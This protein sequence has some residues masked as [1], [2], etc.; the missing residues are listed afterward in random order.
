MHDMTRDE[1][2]VRDK[3][4]IAGTNLS[5]L[6]NETMRKHPADYLLP[7]LAAQHAAR[8][9]RAPLPWL[10]RAMTLFPG[11]FDA[12]L[13]AARWLRKTGHSSQAIVEYRLALEARPAE[14]EQLIA[15][16]VRA[17][18]HF[19]Q[20]RQLASDP[21][22]QMERWNLIA[23][24]LDR[25][26]SISE[27]EAADQA[28]IA[29]DS[30]HPRAL[31]RLAARAI[32]AKRWDDAVA[33]TKTLAG[34]DSVAAARL[35]ARIAQS[36]GRPL[37]AVAS[38]EQAARG[39]PDQ[40]WSWFSLGAAALQAGDRARADQAFDRA[41]LM[42]TGSERAELEIK[43][44]AELERIGAWAEALATYEAAVRADRYR[45]DGWLAIARIAEQ[46][47]N[48]ALAQRARQAMTKS[49]ADDKP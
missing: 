12:H 20:L 7:L 6:L 4:R 15:E 13:L 27:A 16:V 9:N 18:P 19:D 8:S 1:D 45:N 36:R 37:E 32:D 43:I 29:I 17:Y 33:Y 46:Q 23:I 48:E 35:G 38:L 10:N 28:I 24:K 31:G 30:R 40:L 39:A 14:V 25:S 34:V 42:C 2:R 21:A 44:G 3:V 5:P 11:S 26:Q 41:R 49:P 47:G 22:S